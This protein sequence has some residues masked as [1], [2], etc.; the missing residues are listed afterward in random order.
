HAAFQ[1]AR[2][3]WPKPA[4]STWRATAQAHNNEFIITVQTGETEK[5]AEFL[6]LQPEQIDNSA[7]Q[8]NE[9]ATKG[10]RII[11]KKAQELT[12]LPASLR[13]VLVLPT[14]PA[15]IIDA[16]LKAAATAK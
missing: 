2:E 7:P 5:T 3:Q 6:P 13:G 8:R 12:Q 14:G 11:V 1:A 10:I 4:P 16:P 15:Y 9:P